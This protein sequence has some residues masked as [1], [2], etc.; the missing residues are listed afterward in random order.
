MT[1]LE[2]EHNELKRLDETEAFDG[3]ELFQLLKNV[4]M[5]KR[6][7]LVFMGM[8][9]TDEVDEHI[10]NNY[11]GEVASNLHDMPMSV[12]VGIMKEVVRQLRY[13]CDEDPI[14]SPYETIDERLEEIA[15]AAQDAENK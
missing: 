7:Q 2:K 11:E 14:G 3:E 10:D 4:P 12:K 15:H 8:F 13:R 1:E 6:K 9:S 5:Y